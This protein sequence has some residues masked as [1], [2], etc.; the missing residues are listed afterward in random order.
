MRRQGRIHAHLHAVPTRGDSVHR[1][2]YRRFGCA[3]FK[4]LCF[5]SS[6]VCGGKVTADDVVEI[7]QLYATYKWT[8]TRVRAY[9]QA[10]LPSS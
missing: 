10:P 1:V 3:T 9:D 4:D 2:N 8:W 7:Q 5:I 6:A